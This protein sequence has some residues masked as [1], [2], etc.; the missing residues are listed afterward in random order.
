VNPDPH[1]AEKSTD[2]EYP[3]ISACHGANHWREAFGLGHPI[4]RERRQG[5]IGRSIANPNASRPKR[6]E[7]YRRCSRLY[8]ANPRGLSFPDPTAEILTMASKIRHIALRA[9]D[10]AKLATFYEEVFDMKVVGRN[11]GSGSVFMSDGYLNLA[12]LHN[13]HEMPPGLNHFGFQI[14][15]MDKT[16]EKL[17]SAGVQSPQVRPN[18]PPYAESRAADPEGNM[19]DLSVHGYQEEER[20]ADRAAQNKIEAKV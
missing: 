10:P 15:D 5:I 17:V 8:V 3:E 18:N 9:E 4:S 20:Q 16:A 6:P 11:E 1:P 2:G 14:D 19:F 13:R 12:I 7:P